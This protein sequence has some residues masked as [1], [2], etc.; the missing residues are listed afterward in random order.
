MY[1]I[2]VVM[3]IMTLLTQEECRH[4]GYHYI[5]VRE[6][7]VSHGNRPGYNEVRLSGHLKIRTPA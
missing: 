2:T 6:L 1:D 5:Q 4:L 7:N 3:V